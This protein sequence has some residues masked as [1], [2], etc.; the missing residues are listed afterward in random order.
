LIARPADTV[1]GTPDVSVVGADAGT[2]VRAPSPRLGYALA[3]V[4]AALAGLNGSLGRYLLD[5]GLTA[6]RLTQMRA[7]MTVAVLGV[8]LVIGRPGLLRLRAR[9]LP[10]MLHLGVAVTLMQASYFYAITRLEIGVALTIQY[11]A[12]LIVLAW[13]RLAHGRRLSIKLWLIV[14]VAL[15][16]TFLVVGGNDFGAVDALGTGAALASAIAYA[17][18]TVGAERLGD[19]QHPATTMF[20]SFGL[21]AA[22]WLVLQPPW[23]FPFEVLGTASNLSIAVAVGT[24]GTLL[25]FAAILGSL[26]HV[27]AARA[28]VVLMSETAFG[29]CFALALHD[30]SLAVLQI[31]GGC[32][33]LAAI[34]A[35][36]FA[37]PQFAEAA[38]R[39]SA[40]D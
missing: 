13:L 2:S 12:P 6:W 16:G 15:A 11:L 18:Y 21:A 7:V 32:M 34:C 39:A 23:T 19:E 36:Q 37:A 1:V 33:L 20:W 24:V 25:P 17:V 14:T 8:I 9:Q 27:P 22:L 5:D 4:G 26:R 31:G 35:L 30:E 28:G 40:R 29:A 38:P 10:A 3:L